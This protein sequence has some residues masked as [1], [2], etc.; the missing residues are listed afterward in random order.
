MKMMLKFSVLGSTIL[1]MAFV[2]SCG[3]N[4]TSP[5]ITITKKKTNT[6]IRVSKVIANKSDVAFDT[7]FFAVKRGDWPLATS[8][9][10]EGIALF[11]EEAKQEKPERQELIQIQIKEMEALI[12]KAE[13][14]TL[15]K[16]ELMI[17]TGVGELMIL[18]RTAETT[19]ALP[20]VS[21]E[22]NNHLQDNMKALE[23]KIASLPKDM[24]KRA[25]QLLENTRKKID[26][27]KN[28]TEKENK[29]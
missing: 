24:Q 9:L 4:E 20:M 1:L 25:K 28:K 21:V 6:A 14:K 29:K 8:K 19:E 3:T 17:T 2:L 13:A 11:K 5:K 26:S 18:H 23:K 10:K 16:D 7:A 12:P 22:A 15:N 27:I